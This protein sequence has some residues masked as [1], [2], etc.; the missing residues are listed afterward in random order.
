MEPIDGFNTCK[1][2]DAQTPCSLR[3]KL[4]HLF[5]LSVK[6]PFGR[7]SRRDRLAALSLWSAVDQQ[8]RSHHNLRQCKAN[9]MKCLPIDKERFQGDGNQWRTCS[10]E[11]F[12]SHVCS[13]EFSLIYSKSVEVEQN[14]TFAFL[15]QLCESIVEAGPSLTAAPLETPSLLETPQSENM[16]VEKAV[17]LSQTLVCAPSSLC[18]R[19]HC[20]FC[21]CMFPI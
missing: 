5:R 1:L 10:G 7:W 16:H 2:Q 9:R 4:L 21:V 13:G 6:E 15:A 8:G 20:V 11:G 3:Q 19:V 12:Y 17:L 18:V 14:K